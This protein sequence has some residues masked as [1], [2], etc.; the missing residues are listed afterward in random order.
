[1]SPL[2]NAGHALLI[3]V[4]EGD[5]TAPGRDAEGLADVLR[6]ETRCA[7]PNNQVHLLAPA[8]ATRSGM[9]DALEKLAKLTTT[10]SSVIFYFSGHGYRVNAGI[11]YV[12]YLSG[13]GYDP[14]QPE[15]TGV[16]GRELTDRLT[17]VP[18]KKMLVLLDCCHAGGVGG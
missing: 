5:M 17:L 7:Y 3:G 12:Y 11:N 1:M 4:N 10:E 15:T 13:T 9:L 16:S 14:A 6:D 2:F 18:A 8:Q